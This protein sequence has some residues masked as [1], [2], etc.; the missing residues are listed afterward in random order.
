MRSPT[1]A[2]PV[3]A[4]L[5]MYASLLDDGAPALPGSPSQKEAAALSRRIR[6]KNNEDRSPDT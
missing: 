2:A 5:A 1:G 3:A 4:R 6:S